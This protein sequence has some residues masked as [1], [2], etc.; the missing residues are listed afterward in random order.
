MNKQKSVPQWAL[1]LEICRFFGWTLSDL[2]Q[3]SRREYD[4]VLVFYDAAAR[5]SQS[6]K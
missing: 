1:H 5:A 3:L 2:K 6:D 4:Q